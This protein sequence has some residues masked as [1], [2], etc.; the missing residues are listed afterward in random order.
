MPYAGNMVLDHYMFISDV[1]NGKRYKEKRTL[2]NTIGT[3]RTEAALKE[4][5][6]MPLRKT[7]IEMKLC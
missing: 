1:S 2:E 6:V 7:L 3:E 4:T 5:R